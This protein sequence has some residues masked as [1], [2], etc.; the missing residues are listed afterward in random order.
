TY[1]AKLKADFPDEVPAIDEFFQ[2]VRAAYVSGLLYYFRHRETERFHAFRDLTVRAAL[3]RYFHNP[4]LKLVLTGD[5]PHWGSPPS[6]TS[7]VFDSMLR[8][9]YFLGNYYPRGG[10][11]TFADALARR[12]EEFGGDI[13]LGCE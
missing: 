1:L 3:D 5:C 12:F 2:S 13:L 4:R 10:S 7:F 6:R 11:Q 9:S 8:L